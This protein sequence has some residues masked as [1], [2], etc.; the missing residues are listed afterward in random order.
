MQMHGLPRG[1]TSPPRPVTEEDIAAVEG[2]HGRLGPTPGTVVLVA[3]F[4]AAFALYYF[5]NWK[6]LS[7][8]WQIG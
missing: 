6:L 1:V 2:R 8:L 4:L 7:F 3:I 5:T